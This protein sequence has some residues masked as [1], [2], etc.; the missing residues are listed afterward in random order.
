MRSY[1]NDHRVADRVER[2]FDQAAPTV[3]QRRLVDA[4]E[5]SAGPT[6]QDDG[7]VDHG[8]PAQVPGRVAP[9]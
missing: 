7:R 1:D 3:E 8:R 2:E 5:T 4:A 9:M 6:G